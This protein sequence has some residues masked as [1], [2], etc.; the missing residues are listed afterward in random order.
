LE[1]R[2]VVSGGRQ[3]AECSVTTAAVVLQCQVGVCVYPDFLGPWGE[4]PGGGLAQ[5]DDGL[6]V[7]PGAAGHSPLPVGEPLGQDG[8]V[9]RAADANVGFFD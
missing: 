4:R 9:V 7:Q 2:K 8:G 1:Q 6:A 3:V 5:F